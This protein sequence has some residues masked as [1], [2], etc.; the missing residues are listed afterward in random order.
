MILNLCRSI[1]SSSYL[2][3]S[4]G[5]ISSVCL[6]KDKWSGGCWEEK[7]WW[8]GLLGKGGYCSSSWAEFIWMTQSENVE[9]LQ[10]QNPSELSVHTAAA[11]CEQRC[12][13]FVFVLSV[14]ASKSKNVV[15][16]LLI[17]WVSKHPDGKNTGNS[18]E[19]CE[20]LFRVHTTQTHH[21]PGLPGRHNSGL[22]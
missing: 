14:W 1:S 7:T 3:F 13:V 12:T 4:Q 10:G 6:K 21:R 20:S 11:S 18:E 15:R 8:G 9:P 2:F 5:C 16:L 22:F 17:F 19:T